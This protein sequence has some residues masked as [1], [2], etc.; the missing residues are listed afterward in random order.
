MY[1]PMFNESTWY[2]ICLSPKF[3]LI[4]SILHITT[5]IFQFSQAIKDEKG[6]FKLYEVTWGMNDETISTITLHEAWSVN[7]FYFDGSFELFTG[8]S[9]L[10]YAIY[11][12][13]YND[14]ISFKT[15]MYEYSISASIMIFVIAVISG[16]REINAVLLVVGFMFAVMFIGKKHEDYW[17]SD[18]YVNSSVFDTL[19][20]VGWIPYMIAWMFI[21]VQFFRTINN[22]NAN[23]PDFVYVVVFVLFLFYSSFGFNQ[24][25]WLRGGFDRIHME[26]YN[27][28]NNILS[29]SSKLVLSWLVYGGIV[30]TDSGNEIR[31]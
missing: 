17:S 19:T 9:H 14:D 12:I 7:V 24:L 21:I 5:S 15:R 8:I 31:N 3:N 4:L 28:I 20:L 13:I 2:K 26:K 30:N 27:A 11:T 18:N 29:V 1:T 10:F 6:K 16:I 22:S 25:Y 23:P